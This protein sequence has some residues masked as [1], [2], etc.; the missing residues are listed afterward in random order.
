MEF[1]HLLKSLL[2]L[3]LRLRSQEYT[4]SLARPRF[5][6]KDQNFAK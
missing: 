3:L 4:Q 6:L 5:G 1:T 2:V